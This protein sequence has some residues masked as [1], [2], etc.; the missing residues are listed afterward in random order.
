MASNN[1]AQPASEEPSWLDRW[2]ARTGPATRTLM[3]CVIGVTLGS[4]LLGLSA[5]L[6]NCPLQTVQGFEI[7]RLITSSVVQGSL[8]GFIFFIL[9]FGQTGPKS[10]QA[11]GTL[12]L[13]FFVGLV[14]F[15]SSTG[16]TIACQILGL[17]SEV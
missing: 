15:I 4:W 5:H 11:L 13:L 9:S 17:F 6:S 7:Y 16:H 10:E 14:S 1:T 3:Y 2:V 8:L 12:P